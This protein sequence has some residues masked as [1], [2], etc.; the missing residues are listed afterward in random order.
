MS[1]TR[2]GLTVLAAI[3]GLA[4]VLPGPLVVGA[5][6]VAL[7]VITTD[8]WQVRKAPAVEVRTPSIL[9]RG[10]PASI[11]ARSGRTGSRVRLVS[12][13]D[14]RIDQTIGSENLETSL[15]ALRRGT[16]VLPRPATVSVGPLGL[17][18]WM[19]RAGPA[20]TVTVYPDMVAARRIASDV[21]LG[22]FGEASRRS[23]GPLG[24]G[25]ELEAIR[26]YLPDDD[27]RQVNWKATARTGT[28]MSN[29]YRIEQEREVVLLIDTGRLMSA[30]VDD[31]PT[32]TRLDLAVDAAAAVA[33]VADVVGDRV[34]V[35]AFDQRLRRNVKTRRDGGRI[36]ARAI[37]DLEPST[38]DSDYALAFRTVAASKRAFVLILTDLLEETAAGP[39]VSAMPILAR[40]HSVTVAGIRDPDVERTLANPATSIGDAFRT[41]AAID[42]E[43]SRRAAAVA[44]GGAGATIIDA[45]PASLSI[46]AVA[47]YLRAK[48]HARI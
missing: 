30:P 43:R 25:T 42:V 41:A 16:H 10:V 29:T 5:F 15:T 38:A 31:P 33:A 27:I 23:R 1:I 35:V 39:L 28:P 12:V 3:A 44:I 11:F 40:H 36:V 24:L 34:G 47:A 32:R 7:V 48:R 9:S 46:Q 4:I 18:R 2:R 17:G 37:H 26:E 19:H 22:R 21:R 6:L 14:I 45:S 8:A 13:P 20:T